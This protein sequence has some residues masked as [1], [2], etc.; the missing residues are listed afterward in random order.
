[1]WQK[2][3][4]GEESNPSSCFTVS[5]FKMINVGF[6]RLLCY[7]STSA[8]LS[9]SEQHRQFDYEN[10]EGN[11]LPQSSL[12]TSWPGRDMWQLQH[13]I[14]QEAMTVKHL[15][16][17][18]C[19]R[20][21]HYKN[22]ILIHLLLHQSTLKNKIWKS[23]TFWLCCLLLVDFHPEQTAWISFTCNMQQ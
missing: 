7:I 12:D 6:S 22:N 5:E 8:S 14:S 19:A 18:Q 9:V 23:S 1:M 2:I 16:N 21:E 3:L 13:K 10:R 4:S 11:P 17:E 20:S 15:Q